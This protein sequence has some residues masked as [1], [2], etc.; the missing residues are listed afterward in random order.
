MGGSFGSWRAL[1]TIRPKLADTPV[2]ED[3][4]NEG[5]NTAVPD[6]AECLQGTWR[7]MEKL[8][9]S[10]ITNRVGGLSENPTLVVYIQHF[11]YMVNLEPVFRL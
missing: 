1:V 3:R 4:H 10:A 7:A 6:L 11:G 2:Q 8:Y 5:T 9:K